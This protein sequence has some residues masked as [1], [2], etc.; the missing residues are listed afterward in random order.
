MKKLKAFSHIILLL[1]L[2]ATSIGQKENLSALELYQF[3]NGNCDIQTGL[4][5]NVD[6]DKV[7]ILDTN[8]HIQSFDRDNIQNIWVYQTLKHPFSV[9]HLEDG[10]T[11]YLKKVMFYADDQEK[12]EFVG[13]PIQFIEDIIVFYDLNGQ[14]H[15]IDIDKIHR[16]SEVE[17]N[18]ITPPKFENAKELYFQASFDPTECSNRVFKPSDPNNILTPIRVINDQIKIHKFFSEFEN[19]FTHLTRFQQRTAFYPRPYMYNRF[20]KFGILYMHDDYKQEF[21]SLMPIYF[22]WSS[23]KSFSGQGEYAIGSTPVQYLP[24]LE[25]VM[26]IKASFKTHF[27][28]GYFAGNAI[29]LSAGKDFIIANRGFFSDYFS[30]IGT[31]SVAVTPHFN[32]LAL[33]GVDWHEYSLS[34]GFYYPIFGILGNDIFREVLSSQA[35][36]IVKFQYTTESQ[37]LA[38][39]YSQTDI[40]QSDPSGNDIKLINASEMGNYSSMSDDSEQLINHLNSFSMESSFIRINYD[41]QITDEFNIGWDNVLFSGIYDEKIDSEAYQV[42]YHHLITSVHATKSFSE[43]LSLTSKINYYFRNYETTQANEHEKSDQNGLSFA[44]AIEF[45]I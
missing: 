11:K 18:S 35:S 37:R 29:A 13:W 34:G 5:L 10:L 31:D 45:I 42:K 30:N 15:L 7:H 27:L 24:N 19:G 39:I 6:Q 9:I 40:S 3:K 22:R 25:A 20:T 26:N 38:F 23:G 41:F 16:I 33:T 14:S 43:Y 4:V 28:H 8:G 44:I 32:Y 21:P 36:P 1:F 2:L 12:H 17:V